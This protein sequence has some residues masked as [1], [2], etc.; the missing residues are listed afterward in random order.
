MAALMATE[1]KDALITRAKKKRA[2]HEADERMC[3]LPQRRWEAMMIKEKRELEYD[4]RQKEKGIS[5]R[6]N[7]GSD[8]EAL[9]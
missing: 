7:K 1:Q 3:W 6:E 2:G 4:D 8:E 5:T 9:P